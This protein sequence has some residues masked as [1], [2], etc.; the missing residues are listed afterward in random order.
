MPS[1]LKWIKPQIK[2]IKYGK[3]TMRVKVDAT[4]TRY[5]NGKK[6]TSHHIKKMLPHKKSWTG[7]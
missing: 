2:I 1:T 3:G 5:I 7:R 6:H 4:Y